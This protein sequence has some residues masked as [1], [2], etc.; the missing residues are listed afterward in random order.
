MK[1]HH[2][3]VLPT[4]AQRR[5]RRPPARRASYRTTVCFCV[6]GE[7][8]R[9]L[10]LTES[11]SW[12]HLCLEETYVRGSREGLWIG[13]LG[14]ACAPSMVSLEGGL[15]YGNPSLDTGRS[16]LIPYKS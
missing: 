9:V 15:Y 12:S 7:S 11:Q 6:L 2:R 8:V 1:L 16:Q 13:S 4:S 3:V 10:G 14:I 5:L